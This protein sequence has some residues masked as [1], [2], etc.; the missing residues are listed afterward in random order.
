VFRHRR[1]ATLQRVRLALV[2]NPYTPSEIGMR[3]LPQ[4]LLKDL[5]DIAEDGTLHPAICEEARRLVE[6]RES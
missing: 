5:K 6:E 4:L 1:W 3:L 2:R